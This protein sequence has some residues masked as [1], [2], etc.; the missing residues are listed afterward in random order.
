MESVGPESVHEGDLLADRYR[1][2]ALIGEGGYGRVYRATQIPL[3]RHVAVKV[4]NATDD[5]LR[6]RFA[7]EAAIV[8]RLEHPNTVRLLDHGLTPAGFPFLVF[9]LLRGTSVYDRL[10]ERGPLSPREALDVTAQILR[11]LA[12]AHELGIVHRDIK[13]EN[14]FLTSHF[15]QP[16][17]VKVLDFGIARQR[18]GSKLTVNGEALGTPSYMAPEQAL[19]GAIDARTDLYAVGLL[20]AEMVTGRTIMDRGGAIT[21][22]VAQSRQ[23]PVPLGEDLLRSIVGPLVERAV[24]KAPGERFQSAA[25]MLDAVLATTEELQT[26]GVAPTRHGDP[27]RSAPLPSSSPAPPDSPAPPPPPVIPPLPRTSAGA[28]PVMWAL[29]IAAIV[30]LSLAVV[31]LLVRDGR[32]E[33]DAEPRR[34]R[35]LDPRRAPQEAPL[36]PLD[37][38]VRLARTSQVGEM[39]RLFTQAG[40]R[41][42]VDNGASGIH[43]FVLEKLPC[44]G[45]VTVRTL[46]GEVEARRLAA[47]VADNSRGSVQLV[48]GRSFITV[49]LLRAGE[50]SNDADPACTAAAVS[51]LAR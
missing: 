11:S 23:A 50:F 30:V 28:K 36:A 49:H 42:T 8:Q 26:I 35:E 27:S 33:E 43:T 17:F 14:I 9:E 25:E 6:A 7:R 48:E 34:A 47:S 3:G 12:E 10:A 15:G 16:S 13:P 20:L 39:R 18:G 5:D 19:G 22:M 24:R 29:A 46:E 44:V 38:R 21:I 1:I 45:S 2:E 4:V 40:Y 31:V 41:L 37:P 51:L 32:R